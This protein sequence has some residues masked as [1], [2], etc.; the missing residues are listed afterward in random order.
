MILGNHDKYLGGYVGVDDAAGQAFVSGM[1]GKQDAI[2]RA[3]RDV[4]FPA[5][6]A[7][8]VA[9]LHL[10]PR[11]IYLLRSLPSRAT[12]SPMEQF[13]LS[14]RDALL[15]RCDLPSALPPSAIQSLTQPVGNGGLGVR[16]LSTISA[17]AKWAAA[18]SVAAD[19]QQFIDASDVVLPFA[20]ER[21][22]AHDE[23]VN[24]GVATADVAEYTDIPVS[25]EEKKAWGPYSDPRLQYLP[26]DPNNMI[27]FYKGERRIPSLQRMLSRCVENAAL[28]TFKESAD[29]S[30]ADRIRLDACRDKASYAWLFPHP[31][32]VP[33]TDTL[34]CIALRLRLGLNPLP[35]DLPSPCPL[36]NHGHGDVWHPFACPAVRRRAVTSRHDKA[37]DLVCRYARSCSVLA[38]LEPKDFKSLVPDAELHFAHRTV[39]SDLSGVHPT[40]PS[41]LISARPGLAKNRRAQAKHSKYD[42]QATQAGSDFIP[43]V[44]DSFGSMHHEFTTL[45]DSIEK[46]ADQAGFAPSPSRMTRDAF[47]SMFACGWQADNGRII[48]EW[49]RLCRQRLFHSWSGHA[50]L[51]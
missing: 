31:R 42:P 45:I 33:L 30:L 4:D 3:I 34:F 39:L 7:Y 43:L 1:L 18:V 49:Q 29:C 13:D 41:H 6:L 23:L 11:P 17:A 24:A 47:I 44:V 36:C 9:K 35:Y 26:F 32:A 50:M 20:I 51:H 48:L 37:M 27:T 22:D 10:L 21:L 25:D 2:T 8:F 16:S 40:A 12:R 46:E 14:L 5:H 15:H 28:V 19:V 38:R